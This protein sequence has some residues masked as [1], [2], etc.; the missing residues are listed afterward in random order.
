[1]KIISSYLSG[2]LITITPIKEEFDDFISAKILLDISKD[3]KAS[4]EKLH[5][6]GVPRE[7]DLIYPN[8]QKAIKNK[9]TKNE[10]I[11]H[12]LKFLINNETMN[13]FN[14]EIIRQ[15]LNKKTKWKAGNH[16][17]IDNLIYSDHSWM[18]TYQAKYGDIITIN[19]DKSISL[20]EIWRLNSPNPTK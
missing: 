9:L 5:E 8:L 2:D 3:L 4:Q 12:V 1:M 14:Y 17:A 7:N 10:L 19:K 18:S 15:K 20:S 13:Q 6:L 11:S 16:G